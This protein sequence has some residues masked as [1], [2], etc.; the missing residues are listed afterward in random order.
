MSC[1]QRLREKSETQ[2]RLCHRCGYSLRGHTSPARCPEC[3]ASELPPTAILEIQNLVIPWYRPNIVLECFRKRSAVSF[4]EVALHP[5]FSRAIRRRALAL[6]ACLL[7]IPVILIT[8]DH[9]FSLSPDPAQ[10]TDSVELRYAW[11]ESEVRDGGETLRYRPFRNDAVLLRLGERDGRMSVRISSQLWKPR[12]A[13]P[14][15][16]NILMYC[17]RCRWAGQTKV[18]IQVLALTYVL[19]PLLARSR[20]GFRGTLRGVLLLSG[21]TFLGLFVFEAGLYF[22]RLGFVL[23]VIDSPIAVPMARAMFVLA[24]LAPGVV[25]VRMAADQGTDSTLR[26]RLWHIAVACACTLILPMWLVYKNMWYY[27]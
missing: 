8:L 12:N 22:F 20:F 1:T 14:L 18:L 23:H 27:F 26:R 25:F 21:A 17:A 10:P 15:P 7:L 2:E 19:W 5:V 24:F 3:G 13:Y 9:L 16:V 6:L 11:I 4:W